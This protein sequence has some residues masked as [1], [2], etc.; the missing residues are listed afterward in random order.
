VK[1]VT[2]F[3]YG[4]LLGAVAGVLWAPRSGKETRELLKQKADELIEQGLENYESQRE[5]L[6]DTI[7][8]SRKSVLERSEE[9]K[10]RIQEAREKIMEQVDAA[11]EA[12]KEKIKLAASKATEVV[13]EEETSN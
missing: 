6:L 13:P 12:A 8:S 3:I 9:L 4:A 1:K 5:R 10:Q 7:E 2:A 11:T